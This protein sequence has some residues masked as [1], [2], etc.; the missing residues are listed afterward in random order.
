[1]SKPYLLISNDDGIQAKGINFLIDTLSPV[2]DLLVVAPDSPRSG[3]SC[4][5]TSAQPLR[6]NLLRKEDG[7]TVCSC[8][9]TPTDCVKMA[10]NLFTKRKPDLVVGGINHGDNSSVNTHYS[11]TM[12]VA[13]EGALQGYPSIA[14]SL[15]DHRDDADF[16]PLA[17]YLVDLVFK[18]IAVGLPPFT[19]LNVN[20]P[21]R[22]KFEGVRICRMA[23]SRWQ[24]EVV[25]RKH[26]YGGKY[27][28]LAGDCV[29]LEPEASDTDR[30]AL[31]HG[32][33]AITPTQLDLTATGLVDILREVM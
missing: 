10:L 1:M 14:F 28:W 13:T 22:E 26:P 33:V 29:E 6:L 12:G 30:W 16:S 19:C 17:P 9:G 5:I 8:S 3:A 4:S 2:A 27:Y 20:F 25:R 11:G 21:K 32:Y 18:T 31:A 23:K 7:L 24:N 15:C